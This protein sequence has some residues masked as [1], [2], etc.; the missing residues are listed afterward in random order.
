MAAV[1][2]YWQLPEDEKDFFDFLQGT[3]TVLAVPD[4]WVESKEELVPQPISLLIERHDPN[5]LVFGLEKHLLGV[6][7][8][9]HAVEGGIRFALPYMEPCVVA[10]RRGRCRNGKLA[11][12][13]L[14]AYWDYTSADR[15]K[16]V[17]KD[18]EFI[19]WAK[20]VTTWVRKA[21]PEQVECNGHPHRATS[22]VKQAVSGGKLEVVLY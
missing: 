2:T 21:T 22:R 3:E 15:S 7:L 14:S 12:S 16:M 18:K 4:R 6:R 17:E 1:V 13:N 9:E 10:Y 19:R 20:K 8:E 5:Q 11:L